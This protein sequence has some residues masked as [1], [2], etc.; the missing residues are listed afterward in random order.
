LAELGDRIVDAFFCFLHNSKPKSFTPR[1]RDNETINEDATTP[2]MIPV[3]TYHINI[4]G[5][6]TNMPPREPTIGKRP[7]SNPTAKAVHTLE[8]NE[9]TN[10]PS[11]SRFIVNPLDRTPLTMKNDIALITAMLKRL[12]PKVVNPPSLMLRLE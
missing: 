2:S 5:T 12:A 10:M 6:V 1:K 9:A 8:M 3:G 11:A 7:I 4:E